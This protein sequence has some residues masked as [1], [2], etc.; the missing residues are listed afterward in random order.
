MKIS[1]V[2]V[3]LNP[4]N[5]FC[6]TA[7][8]ILL[9]DHPDVEW[10]VIDGLSW[11]AGNAFVDRYRDK[12]DTFIRTP[13]LGVYAAMN[14]AWTYA[15]GDFIVFMNAGDIFYQADSLS[16]MVSHMSGDADIVYG[17]HDYSAG[18]NHL[19]R[20]SGTADMIYNMLQ[21]GDVE[22]EWH[23]MMPC[24]Q[25]TFYRRTLFAE[26]QFDTR[27]AI[28]ADHDF[29]LRM[30]AQNR[31]LVYTGVI[32]CRYYGG[33][34]SAQNTQRCR[35]EW[36]AIY[37]G[38][39]QNPDRVVQHFEGKGAVTSYVTSIGRDAVALAGLYKWEGPYE[40]LKLPKF[41]WVGEAGVDVMLRKSVDSARLTLSGRSLFVQKIEVVHAGKTIVE[42]AVDAGPFEIIYDFEGP[43]SGGETLTCKSQMADRLSPTDSRRSG[44]ALYAFT[45]SECATA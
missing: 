18:G 42:T 7:E 22:H 12:I 20:R 24:H 30:C 34:Y 15:S 17:D 21:T 9:Q 28:C 6:L 25:S 38:F 45:V 36:S 16:R 2:T 5:E 43:V 23:G 14:T 33:G 32:V 35:N 8:S 4:T 13:D 44:W 26:E 41:A 11:S 27:Y 1:V 31:R 39:S 10:V 3:A 19:F 40:H 29:F 37:S